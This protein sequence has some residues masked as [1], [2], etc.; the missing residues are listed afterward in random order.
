MMQMYYLHSYCALY[1]GVSQY[2]VLCYRKSSD[3]ELIH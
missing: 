1:E 2:I 3:S